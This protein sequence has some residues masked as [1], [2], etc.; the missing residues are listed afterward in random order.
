MQS[1]KKIAAIFL[2]VAAILSLTI[3]TASAN[4][5]PTYGVVTASS[6]NIRAAATTDSQIMGQIPNG[7]YVKVNWVEPGWLNITYNGWQTGY[8]CS[9][10]VA[11]YYDEMPSRAQNSSKG[12][13][14]VE[15]AK[16]Y[17]GTP[18]VYGGSSPSGFDCSGFTS[19]IYAQM[20]VRINR[21]A[22]D[23]MKNGVWVDKSQL[24]PGDIVG[25]YNGGGSY[26][27]HVGIYVGNGMMI[28]SP[29]SG[30]VV[31]YESIATGTYANRYAAGR[32]IF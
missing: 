6:L 10:Y 24:Q 23:Q 8:V 32:R 5:A 21:V 22:A 12:Q 31:R 14:V 29:H 2:I 13:A 30:T 16:R 20:G 1:F 9:D 15:L 25:F 17:L 11:V 28:H 19:Y 27:G 26:V 4:G 18:Y 3:I 7:G